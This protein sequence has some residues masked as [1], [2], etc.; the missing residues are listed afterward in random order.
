MT[1]WRHYVS[2]LAMEHFGVPPVEL[3]AV[4]VEMNVR[5]SLVRLCPS[6]PGSR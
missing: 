5:A 6:Y 2:Q 1:W 4:S 3:E